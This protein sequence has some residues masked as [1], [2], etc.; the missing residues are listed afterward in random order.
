MCSGTTR[1]KSSMFM[2]LIL[3][4]LLLT[5]VTSIIYPYPQRFNI[6][7]NIAI[8]D[9][10]TTT[11]DP[12]ST[13]DNENGTVDV[14]FGTIESTAESTP[15]PELNQTN[16]SG[17]VNQQTS[18]TPSPPPA[19]G[20][21]LATFNIYVPL[22]HSWMEIYDYATA[23]PAFFTVCRSPLFK[24]E[25][26]NPPLGVVQPC[27]SPKYQWQLQNYTS[28]TDFRIRIEHT[29]RNVTT[30]QVLVK[31]V[32]LSVRFP[33]TTSQYTNGTRYFSDFQ[34]Q[35]GPIPGSYRPAPAGWTGDDALESLGG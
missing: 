2:C 14:G 22:E 13:S 33:N 1:E 21:S 32:D 35:S 23:V 3:S 7:G 18:E 26:R 8:R 4:P 9:Q 29:L 6:K 11:S 16:V 19:D 34:Y 17:F 12:P 10:P 25:L 15:A 28:A 31:S 24:G 20:T 5:C 27:D 30:S